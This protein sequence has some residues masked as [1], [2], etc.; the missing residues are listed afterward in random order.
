MPRNTTTAR[1]PWRIVF[2][3]RPLAR[4]LVYFAAVFATGFAFGVVRQV[5]LAPW[6]GR[7][8]AIYIELPLM[9][10]VSFAAARVVMA[11][12]PAPTR[13]EAMWIGAVAFGLLMVAEALIGLW[14]RGLSWPEY[15]AHFRKPD[16]AASI[17][18]YVLFGL[19]PLLTAS[20]PKTPL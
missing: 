19:A 5:W 20:R 1:L 4:A 3:R 18:A 16:G 11:R 2:A 14:L 8:T 15:W 13:R 12:T 6:L 7:S 10:L 9:V 17:L